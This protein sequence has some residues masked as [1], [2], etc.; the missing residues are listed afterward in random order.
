MK[1]IKIKSWVEKRCWNGKGI[2]YGSKITYFDGTEL[3]GL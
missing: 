3:T 2:Y 1:K